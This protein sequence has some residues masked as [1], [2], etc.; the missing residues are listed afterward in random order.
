[1]ID[2]RDDDQNGLFFQR[3]RHR[4]PQLIDVPRNLS[5]MFFKS[6]G[7]IGVKGLCCKNPPNG[8][9][10]KVGNPPASPGYRFEDFCNKAV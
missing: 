9:M 5:E 8:K 10:A 3:L 7:G 4:I 1:M 6:E 2:L